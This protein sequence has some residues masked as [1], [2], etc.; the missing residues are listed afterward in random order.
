[1]ER[2]K[3]A[4]GPVRPVHDLPS[5]DGL[6]AVSIAIVVLSHTKVL[7]PA[8]VVHAGLFRYAIGGGIHGVEIFFAISG[9][10]IT[11]LLLREFDRTGTISLRRF[12]ARRSL[13]IFP[14]FYVYLGVLGILWALGIVRERVGTF[15]AAA[16]YLFVYLPH[17]QGILVA[18]AWSLSVEEQFYLL[19]PVLL[20]LSCRWR[21][22]VPFA[23]AVMIGMP[24]VRMLLIML[25]GRN[26]EALV[27]S[28]SVDMLIVGCLLAL[29][30]GNARWELLRRRWV[31]AWTV[32]GLVGLA[33][34]LI[35]YAETK[36]TVGVGSV[37]VAGFGDTVTALCLGGILIYSVEVPE[38]VA[39]R[40]LNLG[41]V[42]HLGIVSYSLYLW[43]QLFA[44]GPLGAHA[45]V[46]LWMILAAE[47]SY[48]LI[49]R[50]VFR[51]RAR[52][53]AKRLEVRMV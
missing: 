2:A 52:L 41:F 16:T 29:V 6:R 53:D 28:G 39:G 34:V 7:L 32:A 26:A 4:G 43:Q 50:P 38:S 12:Y 13:R 19:W 23:L 45:S 9:F 15:L 47:L 35:P 48:W 8:R 51:R 36:L 25:A 49:E 37:I 24:V 30:R 10:L 5:L 18:H 21:K 22:S 31:N 11:T 14:P 44:F 17:P 27:L 33:F 1:M 42:R 40:L 3:E 46:Y 20:F